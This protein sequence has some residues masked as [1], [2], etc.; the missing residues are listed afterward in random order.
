MSDFPLNAEAL[1]EEIGIPL[2]QWP[3]NCHAIAMAVL[4][5]VPVEGMRVARGHYHGYVSRKSVYSGG[6]Q[7]HSWLVAADG[8]ILDPT[9]WAMECPDRPYIYL[10]ID[11]HY[12]E[13]GL[14]VSARLPPQLPGS[15]PDP[16]AVMLSR[17]SLDEVNRIARALGAREVTDLDPSSSD[18]RWLADSLK[19]GLNRPP[20][21]HDDPVELFAALEAAGM[22]CLIKIDLWNMV[23]APETITRQGNANRW[24]TLPEQ[25]KPTPQQM[26][27]DICCKFIS[28][29]EREMDIE[30]ELAELGYSLEDWHKSLNKIEWFIKGTETASGDFSL[31][32]T[33]YLDPLVVVSSNILGKGFGV[34]YR[35]E[36]YAASLGYRRRDLDAVL[37]MAG[38]RIGYDNAWI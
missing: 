23:M 15:G 26:F 29:E 10:G 16:R 27:F 25:Q 31:I 5:M 22:K 6:I 14:E 8:R 2:Q 35:V 37:K 38:N 36:R 21:H 30:G 1:A 11:D 32:P 17:R 34:D 12:D 33:S 4:R 3:G 7:Q 19:Y 20:D 18:L 13:A 24:F 28:I 9:R